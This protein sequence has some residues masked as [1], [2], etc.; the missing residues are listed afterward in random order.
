MCKISDQTKSLVVT[1]EKHGKCPRHNIL[2]WQ[3]STEDFNLWLKLYRAFFNKYRYTSLELVVRSGALTT[4][5]IT[6]FRTDNPVR[7]ESSEN[8]K[9]HCHHLWQCQTIV[10][11]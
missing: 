7:V 1:R 2:N 5:L 6:K 9:E 11:S 4:D 8:N 3:Y 10:D